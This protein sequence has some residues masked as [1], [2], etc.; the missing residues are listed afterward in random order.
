M[1]NAGTWDEFIVTGHVRLRQCP[2]L[3]VL[4]LEAA[5]RALL[6]YTLHSA[7]LLDMGMRHSVFATLFRDRRIGQNDDQF[8]LF[9]TIMPHRD[10]AERNV[11][12]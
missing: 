10:E 1:Q 6:L 5:I 9:G 4:L 8:H 3:Q 2:H 7:G 11:C 12:P